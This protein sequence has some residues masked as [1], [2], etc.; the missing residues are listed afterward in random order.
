MLLAQVLA[1]YGWEV[2]Q[3]E[4][5]NNICH[6]RTRSYLFLCVYMMY[7]WDIQARWQARAGAEDLPFGS[8]PLIWSN[9]YGV[10]DG[11]VT[12]S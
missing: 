4:G 6:S 5:Q 12:D 9:V 2:F 11:I 1:R 7:A 8:H 10:S 3:C